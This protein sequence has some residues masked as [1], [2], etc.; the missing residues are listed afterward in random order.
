[1][2]TST[3]ASLRARAAPMPAKPPPRTR[4]RGRVAV[5]SATSVAL[6]VAGRGQRLVAL[7]EGRRLAV[8]A[9][10]DGVARRPDGRRRLDDSAAGGD[11]LGQGLV[12]R[13]HRDVRDPAPRAGVGQ[14]TATGA[15]GPIAAED[16]DPR[17]RWVHG[18]D[19]SEA[20][21]GRASSERD[22]WANRTGR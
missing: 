19:W 6:A 18:L 4:T 13:G 11:D 8:G 12:Q 1:R 16:L 5:L 17:H 21:P 15:V 2:T 22:D 9:G 14:L 20:H 3:G 7:P 10:H